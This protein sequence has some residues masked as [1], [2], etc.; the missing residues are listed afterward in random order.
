MYKNILIPVAFD[1]DRNLGTSLGIAKA[2]LAS[3]GKIT[4][5]HVIEDLPTYVLQ[6][7]PEGQREAQR[8]EIEDTLQRE[9]SDQ[10]D[11]VS[12]VIT[13]HSGRSIVDYADKHGT[14]CIIVASHRPGLQDYFL[15]STASRI[16]RHAK[17]AVHVTR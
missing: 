16:V 11:V 1:H 2:L 15:G 3:G 17:C 5:L 6:Q 9:T 7:L 14:D 12:A 4:V 8:H 10:S 13:G